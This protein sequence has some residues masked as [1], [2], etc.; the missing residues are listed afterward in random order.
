[1]ETSEQVTSRKDGNRE[2]VT[3]RK[4]GNR[5]QVTSRKDGNRE[6]V[7]SS[8]CFKGSRRTLHSKLVFDNL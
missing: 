7:T 3:S 4:D 1:M 5:E 2:Q 6:Q 8:K